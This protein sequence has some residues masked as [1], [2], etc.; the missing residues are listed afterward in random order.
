MRNRLYPKHLV[1]YIGLALVLIVIVLYVQDYDL[2]P[3]KN[4]AFFTKQ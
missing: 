4:Y 2:R 3:L 1:L